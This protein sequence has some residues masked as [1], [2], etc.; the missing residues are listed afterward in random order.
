MACCLGNIALVHPV[1][2]YTHQVIELPLV[3]M[4]IT[5]W[6]LYQA[7]CPRCGHR[8]KALL[9]PEHHTGYG[10][11]LSALISEM[12]VVQGTSR[13]LIQTFCT[14][15]L[16]VPI[17]LGAIQ[18]VIDRVTVA[19]QPFYEALARIARQAPVGVHR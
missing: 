13:S 1:P 6:F 15:V 8:V 4:A 14:S 3:D 5:H 16:G 10:P 2:Y 12:A 19:L 17:G 9:P 11:Q 7:D 18:K